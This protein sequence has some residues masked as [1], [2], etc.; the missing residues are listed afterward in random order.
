MAKIN[1]MHTQNFAYEMYGSYA[2]ETQN[3]NIPMAEDLLKKAP[4]RVIQWIKDI[5]NLTKS[6][7]V[8]GDVMGR[9]HP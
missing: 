7:R 9:L 1:K 2:A 6:A 4:R 5:H 3:R 8:V